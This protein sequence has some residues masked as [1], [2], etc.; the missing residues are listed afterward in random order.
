MRGSIA[1]LPTAESQGVFWKQPGSSVTVCC[2]VPRVPAL[3]WVLEQ[4]LNAL[5]VAICRAHIWMALQE[6][7]A[8]SKQTGSSEGNNGA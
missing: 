3:Q 4:D 7:I 1:P 6:H 2:G 8:G 5:H